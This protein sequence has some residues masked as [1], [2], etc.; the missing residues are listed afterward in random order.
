MGRDMGFKGLWGMACLF[1]GC[2]GMAGAGEIVAQNYG[3]VTHRPAPSGNGTVIEVTSAHGWACTGLY[4]APSRAG[5]AVGFPLTCS[6]EVDGKALM[7]VEDGRAAILFQRKDG[8]KGSAAFP[9]D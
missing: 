4:A 5:D 3:T 9:M 7:S 8:S 6:D 1:V 2:A